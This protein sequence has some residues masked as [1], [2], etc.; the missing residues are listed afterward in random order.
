MIVT[1]AGAN[2]ILDALKSHQDG[3]YFFFDDFV[4]LKLAEL[5]QGVEGIY[6][7]SDEKYRFVKEFIEFSTTTDWAPPNSQHYDQSQK[8]SQIQFLEM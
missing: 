6:A 1:P 7:P 2:W 4:N 8:N 3:K 5:S